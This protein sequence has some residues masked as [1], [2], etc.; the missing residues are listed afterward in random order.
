MGVTDKAT[1]FLFGFVTCALCAAGIWVWS[2]FKPSLP[3]VLGEAPPKFIGAKTETKECKTLQAL[4][5]KAKKDVGLPVA[6]QKDEDTSLLVVA[7]VPRSENPL[8]A[9][10]V[11]H[12]ATGIGEIY[13]TPQPLPWLAFN[14]R[15]EIGLSW[16]PLTD[17]GGGAVTSLDG[18]IE[19]MQ[20]KAMRFGVVGSV[21]EQ[22][23]EF[24]WQVGVRTWGNF[25]NRGN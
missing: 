13:F 7:K 22:N 23:S 2:T 12:R 3:A 21:S 14:R 6:I 16:L 11:L 1:G 17:K 24:H 15:G 18:R 10:A 5:P 19:L 25:G 8:W 4:A 20:A 9:S